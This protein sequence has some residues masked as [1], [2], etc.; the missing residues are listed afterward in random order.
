ML[1]AAHD[2]ID[3]HRGVVV[4]GGKIIRRNAV[5]AHHYEISEHGM[6]EFDAS[7]NKVVD[8]ARAGRHRKSQ[9]K[10]VARIATLRSLLRAQ[11]AAPAGIARRED[12]G[13]A[14]LGLF[15]LEFFGCTETFVDGPALEQ[16]GGTLRIKIHALR[17][18]IRSERAADVRALV[19]AQPKPTQIVDDRGFAFAAIA[20]CVGVLDS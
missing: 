11:A 9:G 14:L 12:A 17:L 3:L 16:S 13:A 2:Q 20:R 5:R 6:I 1:I 8:D 19:P 10:R 4:G 18:A 7:M 15:A